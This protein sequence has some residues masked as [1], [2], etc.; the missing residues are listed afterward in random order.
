MVVNKILAETEERMKKALEA[1][2]RELATIR[3]GQG[4]AG[5]ARHGARRCV[6]ADGAAPA[7]RQ[8]HARPSRACSSCSRGTSRW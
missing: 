2:R 7:G 5:A 3:S 4:D 1:T 6:R 8:R